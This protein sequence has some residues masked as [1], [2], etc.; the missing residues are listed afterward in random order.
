M[1]LKGIEQGNGLEAVRQLFRTC[2]P[3]SRNRSLG[4][5]HLIMQWPSFDMKSALL[6]QVLKLEDSFREYEKISTSPLPEEIRF[7]VL[8]KVLG[9]QLKTYLQVTL[10]DGTSYEDLRESA[11][12]YDQSTIRWTQSMA[13]GSAVAGDTAI[14]MEVDRVEKGKGKKGKQKGSPKGKDKGSGKGEQKGKASGKKGTSSGKGY[15]N[16]QSWGSKQTSWQSSSWNA[17]GDHSAKG[18]KSGKGGKSKDGGKGKDGTC[19]KCGNYGHFARD[20]RVRSV[21]Q[22]EPTNGPAGDKGGTNGS[23]G[24]GA[25]NRV[26]FFPSETSTPRQLDFDISQIHSLTSF[27]T[28]H[29]NMISCQQSNPKPLFNHMDTFFT[30]FSGDFQFGEEGENGLENGVQ[31]RGT[32]LEDGLGTCG[33]N[34][35]DLAADF[36]ESGT[37]LERTACDFD[38]L[39]I[40][41]DAG[42]GD[43]ETCACCSKSM[44][45]CSDEF[46]K[47]TAG[48]DNCAD[49]F[50]LQPLFQLD[51]FKHFQQ[52]VFSDFSLHLYEVDRN[53]G[54]CNL[55]RFG[56]RTF[57]QTCSKRANSDPCLQCNLSVRAVSASNDMDI[58]LDSGSDV[59]LIP[60]GMA[61]LGTQAPPQPETYLRD[62]QGNA[63]QH[64]MSEMSSFLSVQQMAVL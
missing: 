29:V 22:E 64:M 56:E 20:C 3:S 7:A 42:T 33:D 16:Q 37:F 45:T 32:G 26:S 30:T 1:L 55:K 50:T 12:R 41:S 57:M 15:G 52:R 40:F 43:S 58:I 44:T 39:S 62:A 36:N 53:S 63:L 48:C 24:T 46:S 25:V 31:A 23:A 13:L 59:T 11:L 28:T 60:M 38:A 47:S 6:P 9:G 4:L 49:A 27:S 17:A 2:Q 35:K 34:F 14:P 18:G 51:D 10:K 8:M 5:L 19:H 61:G 54:G 21:G